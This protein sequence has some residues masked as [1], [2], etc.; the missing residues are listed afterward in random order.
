MLGSSAASGKAASIC[1]G[2]RS[3][4]AACIIFDTM[5]VL[6]VEMN[7]VQSFSDRFAAANRLQV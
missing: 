5:V 1:N 4:Q 2:H 3:T 7:V 6:A